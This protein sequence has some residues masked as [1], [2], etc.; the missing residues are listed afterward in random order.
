MKATTVHARRI[1]PTL[2]PDRTRVLLRPFRPSSDAIIKRVIERVMAL[3]DKDVEQ[4]LAGVRG[5]FQDRHE[6]IDNQFRKRFEAVR[7][8]VGERATSSERQALI[9][10]FF[11]HEYSPESASPFH[12]SSL[13]RF[14]NAGVTP[15]ARR[16]QFLA[17]R[18]MR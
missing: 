2:T 12:P 17:A 14:F 4:L 10:A 1:G 8:H 18:N 7:A 15:R 13:A 11:T 16:G 6:K 3:P 9:G 5:E